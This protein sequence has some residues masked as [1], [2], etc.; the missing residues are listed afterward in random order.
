MFLAASPVCVLCLPQFP[1][2]GLQQPRLARNVCNAELG[3]RALVE[4]GPVEAGRA[5]LPS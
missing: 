3:G 1:L 2:P 5:R 4:A